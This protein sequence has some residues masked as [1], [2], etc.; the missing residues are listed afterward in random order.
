MRYSSVLGKSF[1]G[2][3]LS[4]AA[5]SSNGSVSTTGYVA[6]VPYAT[7]G[8][9]Y[10]MWDYGY[11]DPFYIYSVVGQIVQGGDSG[12]LD[13]GASEASTP[14]PPSRVPRPLGALL[15]AWGARI[16]SDCIP[17][18]EFVDEDADGIPASYSATFNCTNQMSGDR[19][20]TLTGTVTVSDANDSSRTAG[21]SMQFTNYVVVVAKTDGTSSSRTLNGSLAFL[22]AN[23]NTFQGTS[24]V[25]IVFEL[26][27][28][29]QV[30]P[31]G[32]ITGMATAIYAPDAS[33]DP[34]AKGVVQFSG[35]QVLNRDYQGANL[36]RRV[37]RSTSPSI[38][39]NRGCRT[40]DPSSAGYDSGT[41]VY[42]DDAGSSLRLDYSGC[43]APIVTQ[44]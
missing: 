18:T 40:E 29:N 1:V 16:K 19:T 3:A 27:E 8:M 20:T 41:L 7:V 31:V 28:P 24:D 4:L 22:P 14:L 5:C 32:D 25:G 36:S 34:F 12:S 17:E 42:Q 10:G 44:N 39:W 2:V 23:G 33:A 6:P 26:V 9:D 43:G 13:G 30:R 37:T 11:Y 35:T 21:L 15:S 38:H